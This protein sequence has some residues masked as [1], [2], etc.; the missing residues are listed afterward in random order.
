MGALWDPYIFKEKNEKVKEKVLKQ[1]KCVIFKMSMWNEN[2][3][4]CGREAKIGK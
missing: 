4:D 1:Q 3:C 2:V